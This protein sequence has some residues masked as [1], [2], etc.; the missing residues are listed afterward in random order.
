MRKMTG[1]GVMSGTSLDGLDIALCEFLLSDD[2]T[3]KI[4]YTILS[5]E[6]FHYQKEWK[7]RLESAHLSDAASLW[8]LHVDFGHYI[9]ERI[10]SFLTDNKVMV[11]FIASH[12]HTV[13][14]QPQNKFTCQIGDGAAIAAITGIKTVCDFRS[15]DVALGGQ[16][17]PLVPVG[18][19]LLFGNYAACLNIGGIANISFEENNERK[20][21]DICP[22]NIIFNFLAQQLHQAYDKDGEIAKKGIIVQA[23]LDKLNGLEYY[24]QTD[25]KSIGREWV[26]EKIIITLLTLNIA[27]EHKMATVL[28]HCAQQIALVIKKN[29]L[30]NVLLTGGGVYNQFLVDRIKKYCEADLIIPDKNTI[31]FKE[32]LVFAFLGCLRLREEINC[33]KSVTGASRNSIGGAVYL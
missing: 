2:K 6:T 22:A 30:E 13:F 28:E 24:Q 9:G 33:L 4:K 26:E 19:K 12:G 25:K 15:T 32:A 14:H 16:G 17:A 5:A 20:A 7:H 29:K 27:I 10:N 3:N 31:E 11:D 21:F 23:L 1:I 8:K 18:D